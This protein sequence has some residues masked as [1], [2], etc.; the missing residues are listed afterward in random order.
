MA[1]TRTNRAQADALLSH[2]LTL[3]VHA[4]E[5][6]AHIS[7]LMDTRNS[8]D[9]TFEPP[10]VKDIMD[11]ASPELQRAMLKQTLTDEMR[12]QLKALSLTVD[13]LYDC[14]NRVTELA[15]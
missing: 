12:R 14:T 9:A 8:L 7:L 3:A 13:S 1:K 4:S 2:L 5:Q 11:I 15:G 10:A 6:M